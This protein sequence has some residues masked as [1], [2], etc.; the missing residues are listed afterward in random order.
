[1][2]DLAR[3]RTWLVSLGLLTLVALALHLLAA[4]RPLSLTTTPSTILELRATIAAAVLVAAAGAGIAA[5]ASQA[6]AR[7]PR[8]DASLAGPLWGALPALL[9]PGG[10]I[11]QVPVA[12]AG[13]G[14]TAWLVG[15]GRGGLPM[16]LTRGLAVA[17]TIVS[18]AALLLFLGPGLTATTA[19][20][21]LHAMLGG[22]LT[23]ATPDRIVAGGLLVLAATALAAA[24]WRG[25]LLTRTG[26]A[27]PTGTMYAIAALASA[28]SVLVGGVLPGLGLLAIAAV[29]TRIGEHPHGLLPGAALAAGLLAL[30]LDA[31]GQALAWPGELPL[32][33]VTGLGASLYLVREVVE[34]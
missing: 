15:G 4:P 2:A 32:G 25:L 21:L 3:A 10:L 12:V 18:L 20:A 14:L 26:L 28:G 7:D 34:R 31:A 9:M 13:A 24:R 27:R 17:G 29:R 8:V 6:Q 16:V 5:V 1:M 23:S 11:V 22:G 30:V 19:L 33:V